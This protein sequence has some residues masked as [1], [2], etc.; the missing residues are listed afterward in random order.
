MAPK[1]FT[2]LYPWFNIA[3]MDLIATHDF[4]FDYDWMAARLGLPVASVK[5]SWIYLQEHG[6]ISNENGTW[7]KATPKT[8]VPTRDSKA[9]IRAYHQ[10]LVGKGLHVMESQTSPAHFQKRIISGLTLTANTEHLDNV[11]TYLQSAHYQAAEDL[12]QGDCDEVYHMALMLYPL[13]R[14]S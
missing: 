9:E 3:L 2:H 7:E 5:A 1:N 11:K 6:L 14:R 8:R 4:R 12:R 13:T 10:S